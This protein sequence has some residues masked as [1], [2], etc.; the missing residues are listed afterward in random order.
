M[1]RSFGDRQRSCI[2]ETRA[3]L[4][5]ADLGRTWHSQ[6]HDATLPCIATLPWYQGAA[7]KPEPDR[8]PLRDRRGAELR[9]LGRGDRV[10]GERA[11]A[12][13]AGAQIW[14]RNDVRDTDA[15][16]RRQ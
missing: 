8:L 4:L 11:V 13:S 12:G 5:Q 16:G 6:N 7:W 3:S 10:Q 1:Q 2:V 15:E 14:T 9:A